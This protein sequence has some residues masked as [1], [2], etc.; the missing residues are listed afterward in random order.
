MSGNAYFYNIDEDNFC[1]KEIFSYENDDD[2][3]IINKNHLD[4]FSSAQTYEIKGKKYFVVSGNQISF[5]SKDK[6]E[7]KTFRDIN[8]NNNFF[9]NFE[10][11][12]NNSLFYCQSGTDF[13]NNQIETKKYE[14]RVYY[15][16]IDYLK[17][18]NK[19]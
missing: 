3:D 18:K 2:D 7:N 9:K 10:F 13:I 19:K 11:N 15:L 5:L 8:I 4:Y 12:E 6:T 1:L 16:D 14:K 17:N